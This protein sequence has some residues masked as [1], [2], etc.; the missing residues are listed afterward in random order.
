MCSVASTVWR[1]HHVA[2]SRIPWSVESWH[3]WLACTAR[4]RSAARAHR[5]R[6]ERR[7][8]T[9]ET[10]ASPRSLWGGAYPIEHG[11]AEFGDDPWVERI[12]RVDHIGRNHFPA[13]PARIRRSIELTLGARGPAD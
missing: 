11:R 6:A 8:G 3:R 1:S 2:R 7:L 9:R 13:I 4:N 5:A 12:E 10:A